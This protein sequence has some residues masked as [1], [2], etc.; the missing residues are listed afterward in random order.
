[1]AAKKGDA[2]EVYEALGNS[3][4]LAIVLMVS[5]DGIVSCGDILKRFH[6]SQPTMSHHL[7]KLVRAG[8]LLAT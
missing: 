8:I 3:V 7:N 4:R 2:S 1:M 6:L 5:R